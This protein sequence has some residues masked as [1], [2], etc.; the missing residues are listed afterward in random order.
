MFHFHHLLTE[1]YGT[2]AS[3]YSIAIPFQV[4]KSGTLKYTYEKY[5][6]AS[7]Q[8]YIMSAHKVWLDIIADGLC[9]CDHQV[10][11]QETHFVSIKELVSPGNLVEDSQAS[12][13]NPE[14]MMI[15]ERK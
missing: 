2:T 5:T 14:K 4:H 11:S 15:S 8:E 13:M 10:K 9:L 12:T 7:D 6:F 3:T 1:V